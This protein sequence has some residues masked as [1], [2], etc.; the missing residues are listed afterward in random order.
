MGTQPHHDVHRDG[1]EWIRGGDFGDIWVPLDSGMPR[2]LGFWTFQTI[3]VYP[4]TER[5]RAPGYAEQ[6]VAQSRRGSRVRQG[7]KQFLWACQR[8][9][10]GGFTALFV[11]G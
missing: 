11:F 3:H 5:N 9:V 1:K 4:R 7:T 6:A 10:E 2:L 8:K